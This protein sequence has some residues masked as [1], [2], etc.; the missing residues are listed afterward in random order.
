[1]F[2]HSVNSNVSKTELR[3]SVLAKDVRAE[4]HAQEDRMLYDVVYLFV[5]L[6]CLAG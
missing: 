6:Y 1:M 2:V 5:I 4:L 3:P